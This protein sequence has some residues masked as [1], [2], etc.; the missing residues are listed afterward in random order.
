MKTDEEIKDL[1][2]KVDVL[3]NMVS[4][5][6]NKMMSKADKNTKCEMLSMFRQVI[7]EWKPDT[8]YEMH[9]YVAHGTDIFDEESK[10]KQIYEVNYEHISE[11][12]FEPGNES[13]RPGMPAYSP[14]KI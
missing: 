2:E 11:K 8:K 12:R 14:M 7:P 9:S 1:Q 4:F 13:K 5:L 10:E 6:A 3:T